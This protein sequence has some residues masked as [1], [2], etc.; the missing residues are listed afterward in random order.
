M[1]GKKGARSKLL[2][3]LPVRYGQD[4]AAVMDGRTRLGREVRDRVQAL[5]IDLGGA[6]T[7][8]HAQRS[9]CRRAIWLELMVEHEETRIADGQG[10]D[11]GP[12][13]QLVNSLLQVYRALGLKRREP[14]AQRLSDYLQA[15]REPS[16]TP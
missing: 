2:R 10:V 11:V 1:A 6:D 14:P 5:V 7:L 4:F 9:L 8:S 3:T 13:V 16:E 15:H 12:H